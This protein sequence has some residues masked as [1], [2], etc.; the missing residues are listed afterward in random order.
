MDALTNVG[1]IDEAEEVEQRYG[2]DDVEVDLEPQ[3]ALRLAIKLDDGSSMSGS[4]GVNSDEPR[5]EN[6]YIPVGR[7]LARLGNNVE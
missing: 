6:W 5:R 4:G 1:A 7:Q 2:R 3:P